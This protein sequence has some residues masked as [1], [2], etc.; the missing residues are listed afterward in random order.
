MMIVASKSEANERK[1]AS[2]CLHIT[3]TL[4]VM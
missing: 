2:I 1:S 3:T 4:V